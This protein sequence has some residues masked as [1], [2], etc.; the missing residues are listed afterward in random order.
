MCEYDKKHHIDLVEAQ[1]LRMSENSK[2]MKTWCIALVSGIIG[3]YV[4]IGNSSLLWIGFAIILLFAWMDAYY[5]LIERQ[6]R[7][8]YNDIVGV[9]NEGENRQSIPPYGM[10]RRMYKKGFWKHLA[11]IISFSIWPLYLTALIAVGVLL[12]V[13][14]V[15]RQENIQK[16][17]LTDSSIKVGITSP[18][19][20]HGN[21]TIWLKTENPIDFNMKIDDTLL[22]KNFN[23]CVK[24]VSIPCANKD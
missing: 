22:V 17:K 6:F 18:V 16:I 23:K 20:T 2:Q 8:I 7:C 9:E 3:I 4:Q 24:Y 5:L 11:P 10:P 15:N 1:I 13:D 19:I 14:P 12:I 21:D